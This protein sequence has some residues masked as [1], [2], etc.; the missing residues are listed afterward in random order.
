MPK[1]VI[2]VGAPRSGTSLTSAIFARQGYFVG[3]AARPAVVQGDDYNPFGYFEADDLIERNVALFRRVGYEF[4]NSWL[5]DPISA[6]AIDRIAEL[7]PDV[8]DRELLARYDTR[9]PWLWKDPRLCLTLPYWARLVDPSNTAVLLILR[10]PDD[11]YWS[12]RR[13]GWCGCGETARQSALDRILQHMQAA[14]AA[15]ERL[16]IPHLTIEYDDFRNRPLPLAQQISELTGL[17]LTVEDLNFRPDLDHSSPRGRLAGYSR[18]I[19]KKLPR[20]SLRHLERLVPRCVQSALFPERKYV[21][22]TQP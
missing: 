21:N 17:H 7:T 14:Q 13:K 1:N 3:G 19:L 16:S 9:S 5:F 20:S 11:V 4:H 22:S 8:A 12:F 2:V 6:D 18:I 10:N 15:V